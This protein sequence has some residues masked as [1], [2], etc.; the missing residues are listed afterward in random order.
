M[1]SSDLLIS[2]LANMVLN[3]ELKPERKEDILL[4]RAAFLKSGYFLE[5]F[6]RIPVLLMR[7]DGGLHWRFLAILFGK[8]RT[9][10]LS[11]RVNVGRQELDSEER[12]EIIGHME[13]MGL[14]DFLRSPLAL[15]DFD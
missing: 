2:L 11:R 5:A 15:T 1:T 12:E 13:K 10:E 3:G 9:D 4:A 7:P 14:E 8:K 6:I